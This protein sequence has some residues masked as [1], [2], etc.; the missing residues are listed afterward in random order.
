MCGNDVKNADLIFFSLT[1][2]GAE[3]VITLVG[4]IDNIG[5]KISLLE[6]YARDQKQHFIVENGKSTILTERIVYRI[7]YSYQQAIR[8]PDAVAI[9]LLKATNHHDI[10]T[11][12]SAISPE[13]PVC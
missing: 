3:T 2:I 12:R 1:Y 6:L 13:E 8:K 10:P 5:L 4:R 7:N 11:Q 9:A